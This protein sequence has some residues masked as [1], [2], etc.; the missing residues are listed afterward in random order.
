MKRF[1]LMFFMFIGFA[2]SSNAQSV[3]VYRATSFAYK[4]TDYYGNW[5]RWSDWERFIC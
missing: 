1:L 4:T 2:L 3:Q 5:T